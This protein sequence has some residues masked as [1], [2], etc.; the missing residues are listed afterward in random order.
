MLLATFM[1]LDWHHPPAVKS[2]TWGCSS[3]GRAR[4]Y[5][6]H[7]LRLA[8]TAISQYGTFCRSEMR[9]VRGSIPRTSINF[10]FFFLFQKT[11]AFCHRIFFSLKVNA[12]FSK[13]VF[14]L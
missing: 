4:A 9:E 3:N 6:C 10:F 12:K 11:Y 13:S 8:I 1:A 7:S 14:V 5:G 2:T